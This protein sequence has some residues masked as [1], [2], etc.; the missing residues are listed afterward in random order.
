[1]LLQVYDRFV[2]H[3]PLMFVLAHEEAWTSA[4]IAH[5][6]ISPGNIQIHQGRGILADWECAVSIDELNTL[7]AVNAVSFNHFVTFQ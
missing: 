5:C 3:T 6:D 4:S 1:M 7:K 2:S